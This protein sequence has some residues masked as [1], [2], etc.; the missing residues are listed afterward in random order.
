MTEENKCISSVDVMLT[1]AEDGFN[2]SRSGRRFSV[3]NHTL[4]LQN[5]SKENRAANRNE[6]ERAS[7]VVVAVECHGVQVEER[8]QTRT[9]AVKEKSLKINGE[10]WRAMV[11]DRGSVE[12]VNC[13][14]F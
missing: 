2:R 13:S 11:N 8:E 4:Q 14:R 12:P 3:V 9:P 10:G 7:R 5:G 1:A 6:R